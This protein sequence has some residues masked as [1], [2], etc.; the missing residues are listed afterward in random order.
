[1]KL[2]VAMVG[3]E[4]TDKVIEAGRAGGATGATVI[5]S[6]RGEGLH[7]ERT[8]LGLDLAAQRD[9]ILFLVV[10]SRA[11]NILEGIRDVCRMD[12][13]RGT[14]IAFQ[15]AVEDSVGLGSQHSTIL[16]ELE[17]FI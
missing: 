3:D 5:T 14:G 8:F 13:A 15:L 7:P 1:M 10:E 9:L 17:E 12:S 4:N 11:R 16:H 6:V 2:I